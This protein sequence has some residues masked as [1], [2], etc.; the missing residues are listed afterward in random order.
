MQ[1]ET[2]F[3][4]TN[5]KGATGK[6]TPKYI[7]IHDTGNTKKSAGALNH[8]NWLQNNND[9][10][11][12]AHVF[13]DSTRAIQV[14]P[15]TTPAYH[16]GVRYVEKPEV[17]DCTNANSIGVEFCINADGNLTQTLT[18]LVA[19]VRQLMTL[20]NIPVDNVI[21]HHMSAGK[22]CPGTFMKNP[23]LYTDFKKQLTQCTIN[24]AALI[25]ALNYLREKGVT[26]A[27]G[28]WITKAR[29]IDNVQGL[30]LNMYQALKKAY[31]GR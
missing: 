22:N 28:Y 12:S 4:T 27:P 9:L 11:R 25:V 2:M 6:N 19:V 1:I 14:I 24:E 29:E 7:V 15:Y 20:F 10:G 3:I 5:N 13:V 26:N 16:I 23:S 21:T 17:S 18:N 30:I 8:Y 31:E